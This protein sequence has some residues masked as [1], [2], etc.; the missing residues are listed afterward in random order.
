[1]KIFL[2]GATG[3]IGR[4]LVPLLVDSGYEVH[5]M[6]RSRSKQRGL[7]DAGAEPVLADGLDRTAVIK[8]VMRAEPEVV[9]HEMTGLS[10]MKGLRDFDREFSLTNKLRTEGTDHLL[11]AAVAAGASRFIAQSFGN[12]N[13]ERR[14]TFAK[15]EEDALDDDPP[16]KQRRTLAAIRHVERAVSSS[17]ALEGV[18]LRYANLYGPGT[19][20]A[21]D[22]EI[23]PL[24]RD[25]RFPVMGDGAGVWSFVH[26][27][28][29]AR[30]TALAIHRGAPGVY[31]VADDEPAPV[32]DWLPELAAALGAKPPRH[33]PTWVGRI[34]GGE[35]G[36]SMMTR[37]RGA[38]NARAKRE[39]GW[40]L[41]YPTWREG[42][43]TG[44]AD[45]QRGPARAGAL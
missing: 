4:R 18:A 9:I 24:L 27:D 7:S 23:A 25:R 38:S 12:W 2:A 33:V 14:G 5:A 21:A 19:G 43:R 30:A 35:V 36:V 40:R 41:A 15:R 16:A 39:L 17:D 26:V 32:S 28:D 42:F 6:T 34:A 3:A 22:G 8:A 44:L 45:A 13:Y 11:E 37:I 10:A 1:M 31:N 29:A 20:F